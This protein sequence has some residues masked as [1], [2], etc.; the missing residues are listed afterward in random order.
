MR[1]EWV[2]VKFEMR[3]YRDTEIYLISSLTNVVEKLEDHIARTL[4]LAGSQYTRYIEK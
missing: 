4:V 2:S 1:K 3:Q